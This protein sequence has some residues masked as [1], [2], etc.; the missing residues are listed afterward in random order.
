MPLLNVQG[1]VLSAGLLRPEVLRQV[2]GVDTGEA[3][4]WSGGVRVTGTEGVEQPEHPRL[5]SG[6][7]FEAHILH[8]LH[9]A[10]RPLHRR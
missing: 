1:E 3:G 7:T 9:R 2:C 6:A 8:Q 10:R 5:F 4:W